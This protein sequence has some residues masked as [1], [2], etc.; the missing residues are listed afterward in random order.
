MR[1]LPEFLENRHSAA[2]ISAALDGASL[3]PRDTID[4]Q[5]NLGSVI[6]R[7]RRSRYVAATGEMPAATHQNVCG[8]DF[9]ARPFPIAITV[10]T[11][12][13]RDELGV[14]LDV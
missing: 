1:K 10:L 2:L 8:G 4:S 11:K 7:A 12:L 14:I 5:P 9:G 13:F 3:A 6:P